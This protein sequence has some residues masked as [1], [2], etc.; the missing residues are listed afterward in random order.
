MKSSSFEGC[1][2]VLFKCIPLTHAYKLGPQCLPH[3]WFYAADLQL[4]LAFSP[5]VVLLI[6]CP[7][8]GVVVTLSMVLGSTVYVALQTF[9]SDLYPVT[10]YFADDIMCV[11]GSL[12]VHW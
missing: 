7:K 8:A 4:L 3:L 10:I 1:P 2:L 6:K 9:Y 11:C 5:A 12:P